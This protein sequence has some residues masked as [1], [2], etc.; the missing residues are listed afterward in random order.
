MPCDIHSIAT[1][2]PNAMKA[3]LLTLA[4][5]ITPRSAEDADLRQ[6]I[7]RSVPTEKGILR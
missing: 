5:N 4:A 6:A 1:T 3:P 2:Y 7:T